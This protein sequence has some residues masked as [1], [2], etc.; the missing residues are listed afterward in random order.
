MKGW[1]KCK[2]CNISKRL[3]DFSFLQ[4]KP[5]G[6][7]RIC[8][9]V[10]T[11]K[12]RLRSKESVQKFYETQK[13]YKEKNNIKYNSNGGYSRQFEFY[14]KKRY[15]IDIP[16][17]LRI[18]EKQKGLC[19]ICGKTPEENGKKLGVDHCHK[20]L[21]VRGLLC[22]NCNAGLGNF[23]ETRQLFINAVNYLNKHK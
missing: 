1:K 21:K 13:R 7:C 9:Y 11:K 8:E 5:L 2:E 3:E 12:R 23:K 14:I 17:Y 10:Y 20:T 4:G 22:T 18:F 6:R 19:D 15:G 16:E